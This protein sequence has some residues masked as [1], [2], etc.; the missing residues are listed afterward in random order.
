MSYLLFI[1][2]SLLLAWFCAKNNLDMPSD[3]LLQIVA[4]L[5]VGEVI[6]WRCK[7]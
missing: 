3:S 4:I 2:V 5:T 7:K 6:S 1:A